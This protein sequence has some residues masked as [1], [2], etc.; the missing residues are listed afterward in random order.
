MKSFRIIGSTAI[1]S[2]ALA[3]CV[4]TGP[5]GG[6]NVPVVNRAP[7]GIDGSWVDPNGIVSS[8]NG[9]IFETR[10]TDT[11][12][13]LAEGNYRYQS[14][15]L[16]EIDMRSIVRGTSSRVNCALVSQNQLNC[17]SSAGSR[18]SLTRRS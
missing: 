12:E 15:Q 4:A 18:F 7:S 11:N 5:V 17:T 3:G 2:L 14:P 6:G 1:V 10:A 13:K 8:F 16:V 9:G